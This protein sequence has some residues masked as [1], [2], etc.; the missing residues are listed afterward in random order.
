MKN[1]L[2]VDDDPVLSRSLKK[3]LT[4]SG[5]SVETCER[6]IEAIDIIKNG[7]FNLILLDNR[8]PDISGLDL[9]RHIRNSHNKLPVIVMTA[10]GTEDTAIEAMKLGAYDYI[11]KPFDLDELERI[12]EKGIEANRLMVDMVSFPFSGD[13]DLGVERLIGSSKKMQEIYKLIG[14]VAQTDITVLIRGESGTGKELVAR[15]IYHHSKRKDMPFLAVNCA[16]IPETL[17][18]SELFGYEKGA[19]TGAVKRRIGKFEQC[20]KGTIFLDEIG[21]MTLS[22]QAKVLRVLQ[23]GEFERVGGEEKI[24]VDVRIIAATNKVLEELIKEGRFRED[25]YYRLETV[26]ITIPPLRKRPED[27]PELAQY[28]F[29]YFTKKLGSP[30]KV[31]SPSVITKLKKYHWP[32]N[33]RELANTIQRGIVLAKG[34][35]L[36]EDHIFLGTTGMETSLESKEEKW[37]DILEREMASVIKIAMM[38]SKEDLY[39]KIMTNAERILIQN[40]LKETM[41]NQ[42]KAAKALGIS[43]NTLRE[44]M[45]RY[46]ITEGD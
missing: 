9:L 19:F 18:E 42:V 28:F 2:I 8:L 32:G 23:S 10:F 46:G 17:L 16:A 3:A 21:D 40:V 29:N 38:E 5:Y 33:V 30:I 34:E 15:S 22:T 24:K 11:V 12:I 6:G 37:E 27:I 14:Q 31:M 25:L 44:R 7:L 39:E 35:V 1:I 36:T 43:R 20:H 4:R 13:V 41:G 45:I 26:T